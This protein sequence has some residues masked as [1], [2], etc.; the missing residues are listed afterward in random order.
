[1]SIFQEQASIETV[2]GSVA[3][4]SEDVRARFITRTYQHLFGAIALFTLIEVAL[5]QSGIAE[6]MAV[7]M[8][9]QSWLLVL[10]AFMIAGTLASRAA[11]V[12]ESVAA[13][14]AA[15]GGY[16]LAEAII[17]VPLLYLANLYAPGT[18]QSA[19][20]LTLCGFTALTLIAFNTRRD[21]SFMGSFLRWGFIVAL[22][23]IVGSVLF[24]FHLGT[25]FSVAMVGMA[26]AAVLYDTSNIIHHFPADKHVAASLSL[27]ASVALMFWYVLRL[28]MSMSRD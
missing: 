9:G 18:I 22:L 26:G 13:Q 7:A 21:F 19:A 23:A 28:L 11:H 15:L 8:L 2:P 25:W 24:G 12:A 20:G 3:Y 27:F 6:R 10:G 17:F 1:M 16:V 4:E 14:Y 5:F